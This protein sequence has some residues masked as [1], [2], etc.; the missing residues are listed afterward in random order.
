MPGVVNLGALK[1]SSSVAINQ[2]SSNSF[3]KHGKFLP[4]ALSF[5]AAPTFFISLHLK[6]LME[7]SVACTSLRD[8]DLMYSHE[9]LENT[10]TAFGCTLTQ[11][12]SKSVSKITQSDQ[13][14]AESNGWLLCHKPHSTTR[15]IS[16]C[17][18]GGLVKSSQDFQNGH[19]SIVETSACFSDSAENSRHVLVQS[20]KLGCSRVDLE[21]RITS[22]EPLVGKN[23]V[24]AGVLDSRCSSSLTGL[25]VEIPF[26]DQNEVPANGKTPNSAQS[27]D[28]AWNASDAVGRNTYPRGPRSIWHHNRESLNSSS[29]DASQLW[30][31]RRTDFIGNGFGNGPKK[32]RTQVHYT[33]PSGVSEFSA[34]HKVHTPRVVPSKR[35]RKANEKRTLDD[36]RNSNRRNLE[37]LACDANVLVTNGDNGDRG[38]RECGARIVLELADH[39]EWRLAVKF[40]GTTKYSYKAH[41]FLQPGQPNRYT[42]AMTWKGEKD[43]WLEFPDRSQWIIFKE[44]HQECY[45]R[46]IRAASVKNIPIPGVRLI[47]EGDDIGTELPFVRSSPM[48]FQQVETDVDMAMDPLRILY[49]MDSDDE[50][51]ISENQYSSRDHGSEG[52]EIS[53]ELFEKTMDALE[54]VAYAEQ[55]DHFT[56]DEMENFMGGVAPLEVIKLIYDHW[57]LKRQRKGMPL[58]RHLQPPLWERYEQQVKEWEHAMALAN[59]TLPN[60]CQDKAPPMEKPL[61]YAFCLKPRGLELPNKGSKQRSH[62]KFPVSGHSHAFLGDHDGL[63]AFGRRNG[64]AFGDEKSMFQ[65]NSHESSDAFPLFQPSR[66]FSPRDASGSGYFSSNNDW[67]DWN[68]PKLHRNKSKKIGT[69]LSPSPNSPRMLASYNQRTTIGRRN[70]VHR[71][72]MGLPEW[73]NQKHYPSDG[74]LRQSIEQLDGPD[75][76]EFRLRDASG[77]AH[78]ALTMARL[79]REN[80]QRLLYRADLAIHKAVVALTTAEAIK[81]SFSEDSNGI[82]K[83]DYMKL[84]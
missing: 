29:G 55:R 39:N 4:F 59:T 72:N 3:V 75:L 8:H 52:E 80:A 50:Q 12:C 69:L 66:V 56:A 31:N 43:W 30:P 60:G 41:Q 27:S 17:D 36:S 38:W 74:S 76:D 48:Y 23:N 71:W 82:E 18:D 35:I 7:N 37:F 34:K 26:L 22:P 25:S 81:A 19:L 6:L 47:E 1:E 62:R 53:E 65:G 40:S 57:R 78:H 49:D 63:H 73:P 51:W 32:P 15:T 2:Y 20:Q 5:S 28:L 68:Y 84:E 83:D 79:K 58:I 24:S 13:E 14:P 9:R 64:F 46:N 67:S 11:D 16:K 77:A 61:V 54:K 70:G 44:I 21:K 42:H 45:N 10:G 33:L